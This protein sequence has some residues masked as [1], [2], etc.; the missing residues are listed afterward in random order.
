MFVLGIYLACTLYIYSS[1][2][3]PRASPCV[4]LGYP[5]GALRD[6]G[7]YDIQKRHIFSLILMLFFMKKIF[8]SKIFLKLVIQVLMIFFPDHFVLPSVASA[9]VPLQPINFFKFCLIHL[10]VYTINPPLPLKIIQNPISLLYLI[11]LN[12]R[13]MNTTSTRNMT[14]RKRGDHNTLETCFLLIILYVYNLIYYKY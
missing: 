12:L 9:F 8:L 4:F 13:T 2:F 1:K 7:L 11:L 14:R 5:A 6:T 10:L 3:D